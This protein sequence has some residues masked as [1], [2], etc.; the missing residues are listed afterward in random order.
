MVQE[1][2]NIWRSPQGFCKFQLTLMFLFRFPLM[3]SSTVVHLQAGSSYYVEAVESNANGP[4]HLSVGVQLPNG[5]IV[6][7]IPGEFLNRSPN[8][9]TGAN[10]GLEKE[11][12]DKAKDMS[13][14]SQAEIL[15]SSQMTGGANNLGFGQMTGGAS[16]L[17]FGQMN[18]G[19]SNLGFGTLGEVNPSDEESKSPLGFV[20]PNAL[21]GLYKLYLLHAFL[22]IRIYFIRILKMKW[23]KKLRICSS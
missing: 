5:L 16:N 23:D 8:A 7:P 1:T 12:P 3:Q 15:T 14:Y 17:G 6:R 2:N 18:G 13:G 21:S 9:V 20:F 4:N 22:F 19:A 10:R 11:K